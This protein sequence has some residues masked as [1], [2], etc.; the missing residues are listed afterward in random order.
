MP[1]HSVASGDAAVAVCAVKAAVAERHGFDR[2]ARHRAAESDGLQLGDGHGDQPETQ[3]GRHQFLKGDP[4]LGDANAALA[5]TFKVIANGSSFSFQ[6][7]GKSLGKPTVDK[8]Y[9][10]G[11][12]GML[13]NLDGTEIAF[14]NLLIIKV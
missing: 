9:A 1:F 8:S 14:S 2:T 7:N 3:G 4:G 12:V 5:N 13:V 11:Y 6:V 10:S